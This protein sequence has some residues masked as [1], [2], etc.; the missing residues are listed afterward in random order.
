MGSLLRHAGSFVVARRFF[1][2]VRG[3]LSSCGV[4]VF[5]LE[6][7]HAGSRASGLCSCGTWVP[8]RMGSVVCGMRALVE[9]RELSNCGAP[10]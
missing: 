6:L 7:W 8:D 5:S 3:L 10:S 4:W 9:A 2:V 1:V